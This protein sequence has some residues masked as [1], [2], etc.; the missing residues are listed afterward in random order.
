MARRA[1]HY[2]KPQRMNDYRRQAAQ[3]GTAPNIMP[4][5]DIKLTPSGGNADRPTNFAADPASGLL[6]RVKQ[7]THAVS[8]SPLRG[9]H[10]RSSRKSGQANWTDISADERSKILNDPTFYTTNQITQ[11]PTWM[12]QQILADQ[13]IQLGQPAEKI[14]N[15]KSDYY[16]LSSS[17]AGWGWFKGQTMGAGGG[18]LG[19]GGG[20]IAGGIFGYGAAKEWIRP[21]TRILAAGYQVGWRVRVDELAGRTDRRQLGW[22]H[23]A[24]RS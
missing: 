15:G 24:W 2:Y 1:D 17:P 8:D 14:S 16:Q 19:A 4:T 18:W 13:I 23:R 7:G 22:W 10:K 3:T 9:C 21:D 12:Q 11:Y 20:A 5:L 6:M